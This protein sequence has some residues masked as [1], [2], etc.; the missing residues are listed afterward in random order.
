MCGVRQGMGRERRR[1]GDMSRGEGE[2]G[3]LC[4]L[5]GRGYEQR[6]RCRERGEYRLLEMVHGVIGWAVG[7]G[8]G[9][10]RRLCA[11]V[12]WLGR[13]PPVR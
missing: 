3:K 2:R 9:R 11:N 4:S 7:G 10:A 5:D 13:Q 12:V 6:G 8:A 1:E